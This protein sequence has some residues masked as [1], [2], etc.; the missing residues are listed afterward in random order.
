MRTKRRGE[1][2]ENLQIRDLKMES[3][4]KTQN[5][6]NHLLLI[7]ASRLLNRGDQITQSR[8]PTVSGIVWYR[9]CF[10][11]ARSIRVAVDNFALVNN[12]FFVTA[13]HVIVRSCDEID[14]ANT[15]EW[16]GNGGMTNGSFCKANKGSF[17]SGELAYDEAQSIVDCTAPSEVQ[18]KIAGEKNCSFTCRVD[19]K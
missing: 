3:F 7:A 11:E 4:E 12:T 5:Y 15:S 17:V 19:C 9:S 13:P 1:H 18:T 16:L 14:A 10:I 6:Y 2:L 8:R